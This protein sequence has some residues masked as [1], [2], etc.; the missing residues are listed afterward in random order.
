[1]RGLM[2]MAA[3]DPRPY[4]DP[5]SKTE[6]AI[7]ET[8]LLQG[9]DALGSSKKLDMATSG[10]V[11]IT[12]E[13]CRLLNKMLESAAIPGF[14]KVLFQSVIRGGELPNHDGSKVE[15]RPDLTFRSP[16]SN[17][18]LAEPEHSALFVE[19][20]VV[21]K[22]HPMHLYCLKGIR[23]FVDGTYAWAVSSALMLGYARDNYTPGNQLK[24]H[25]AN[26]G[27]SYALVDRLRLRPGVANAGPQFYLSV[28]ERKISGM[29]LGP[30]GRI[31][32]HHV[33][34]PIA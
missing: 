32:L 30:E 21:D 34:V 24:V 28:H 27:A 7:I 25:L 6:R 3:L 4:P 19:C 13:L 17:A 31:T 20:K 5:F 11:D 23:R 12:N 29:P 10:E 8:A 2:R 33:W 1:M 14:T 22:K 15:K 18:E 26:D 9:V 16:R